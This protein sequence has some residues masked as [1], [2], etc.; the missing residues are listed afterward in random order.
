MAENLTDFKDIVRK[1]ENMSILLPDF[2]REFVWRDEEQQKQITAS[3]L[4][5]MPIGSVLLLKSKPDEY[6]SKKIGSKTHVDATE[7]GRE[8]EFLLDGQQ[9]ITVLANVFS[10]IIHEQCERVSDLISPSLK[11]RFFLRIPKWS[12]CRDEVDLFGVHELQFKY[13][14]PDSE[15]PDF[16][17][18]D[19][20]PFI[21][22]LPFLV[23]DN[24]PYNPQES[25]TTDLD[26]FCLDYEKGYLIPLYLLAPCE[27]KNKSQYILRYK[28]ITEGVSR[29][30]GN[31]IENHFV[32]LTDSL[33]KD[34]FIDEIFDEASVRKKLKADYSKFH[35]EICNRGDVW[36]EYLRQY[37]DA[38]VKSLALNR[39]VVKEEQRARAIDI[40]ENLNRGGVSLNTFDLIMA[41]VA[42][43]STENFYQRMI[44][45]ISD[46]KYY[47]K[48]TLPDI[49]I[50]LI[51]PQIDSQGYNASEK[52]GSYNQAKNEIASKYIDA[53]LDVLSLHCYNP[54]S[55]P[56]EYKIE[57][58][59]RNQILKLT[60]EQ[61]DANT[62]KVCIAIDRALFFFQ[63]RCGIRSIQE[64]NYSLMI[65]LVASIFINDEYYNKKEVHS[66]LEAWYWS[67]LFGGEYDKDQG[68]TMINHLQAL[69]RTF[70]GIRNIDWIYSLR[71]NVFNAQNFSDEKFLLM[72]KVDEDRYPK[73]VFRQFV[74]QYLLSK[75]YTDMFD[76]TKRIS[77]FS[78][79]AQDLE[80]HHII[81][82]GS[83]SKVF[84]STA[85]LRK[86][87]K[88]ICNSPLNF[89]F[90]TSTAN[91][92][93]SNDSL[94][95]YALK[96]TDEAKSAL[97]INSYN[98][99][100]DTD[101]DKKVKDILKNRY[102]ALKGDVKQHI[103]D[104]LV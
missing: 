63:T 78:D 15:E 16:L 47:N 70:Q 50:G 28:A 95:T 11:K 102:S 40:Y 72:E 94:E 36:N 30:I 80:A 71:D 62:Q 20:Y 88:N 65:V 79:V 44:G 19:I 8:V 48:T 86:D 69:I 13:Q 97:H 75:T 103:S 92:A 60:P 27:K 83:V 25:L 29:C 58:I 91:K 23:G 51:G 45:Y 18:A 68:V 85:K 67:S 100:S 38:C 93:I 90:I 32:S 55:I 89:V 37:L 104:L 33:K 3:V 26:T 98:N 54:N 14:N 22:C 7:L 76:S 57:N 81:P 49:I 42:K 66:I 53:F 39:I 21:E 5:R 2:Q 1:I 82:L 43:V 6:S 74:C 46:T 73:G 52:M 34:R 35:D 64:L 12:K 10:N 4:A 56:E 84:E 77:V 31:E 17:S 24:Q 101:T 59:K 41:R 9:R 99:A 61:I 96:L 87:P